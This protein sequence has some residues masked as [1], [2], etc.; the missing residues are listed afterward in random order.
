MEPELQTKMI[1]TWVSFYNFYAL[2]QSRFFVHVL[3]LESR[4]YFTQFDTVA[5]TH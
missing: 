2:F 4:M 1:Y 5:K 3:L